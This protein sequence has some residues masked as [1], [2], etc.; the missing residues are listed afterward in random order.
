MHFASTALPYRLAHGT[1]AL[2]LWHH[3]KIELRHLARVYQPKTAEDAALREHQI[4]LPPSQGYL[5]LGTR[6]QIYV[7]GSRTAFT[8]ATVRSS[9]E[10]HMC[11]VI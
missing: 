5:P 3:I 11:R 4:E 7:Y 9:S 10:H 8:A 1:S 2:R 6:T